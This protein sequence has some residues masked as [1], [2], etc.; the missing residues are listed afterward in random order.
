MK[1]NK[2]IF[3]KAFGIA[4]ISLAF[5]GCQ[6]LDRPALGNYPVDEN[7][8]GGPLKFYVPF[9]GTTSNPL[10]NAVDQIRAKF[11]SN[12]PFTTIDGVNGKAVQGVADKFIAYSKPN[13]WAKTAESFTVSFWEKHDGQTKN[14][15]NPGAEE[16]FSLPSS[17][18]H[19]S[20]ATMFLLFDQAPTTTAAAIKFVM[21]DA[22][23][24]DTWLTWEG[25][26]SVEGLLDNAWHHI[27]FVYD[28]STSGMTL[29]VDGTAVSTKTWSG[30][31]ALNLDDSKITG[32]RIGN[33]PQSQNSSGDNWLYSNW[34]GGL[35]QF[36]MYS[37]VLT[38][39]EI[40]DLYTNH[41]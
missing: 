37:T 2:T 22:N 34:K 35:D 41:K 25:G 13:D 18:G 6:N 38:P 27:L 24:A 21:V 36:R 20:G 28:A 17:N 23:M 19:W 15:L 33:G 26:N 31:G 16:I 14:G 1:I 11:P 10:M 5:Y 12:N 32:F 39:A 9:D 30:H 7:P 8:V 29:Y 3:R 4:F 40:Q